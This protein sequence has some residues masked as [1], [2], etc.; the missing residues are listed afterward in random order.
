MDAMLAASVLHD[1]T[2]F[3]EEGLEAM[4]SKQDGLIRG[5]LQSAKSYE[6]LYKDGKIDHGKSLN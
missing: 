4:L 3:S 2:P 1:A 6:Q 5:G